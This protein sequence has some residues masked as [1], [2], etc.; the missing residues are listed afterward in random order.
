MTNEE[1]VRAATALL[2]G[3]DDGEFPLIGENAVLITLA[4]KLLEGKRFFLSSEDP[5]SIDR[6]RSLAEYLGASVHLGKHPLAPINEII[7]ENSTAFVFSPA[8]RHSV[9]HQLR[10]PA[11]DIYFGNAGPE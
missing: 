5:D 4:M 3:D 11:G 8:P 2:S 10:L 6:A 9:Y 1:I 7:S